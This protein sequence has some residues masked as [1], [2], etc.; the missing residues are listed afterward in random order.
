MVYIP[1]GKSF[2]IMENENY[3]IF[4]KMDGTRNYHIEWNK[5]NSRDKYHMF[6]HIWKLDLN[7]TATMTTTSSNTITNNNNNNNNNNVTWM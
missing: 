5:P 6:S 2:T 7:N 1:N 3:V 4:K